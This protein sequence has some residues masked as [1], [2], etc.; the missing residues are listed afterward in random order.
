MCQRDI[1]ASCFDR[2]GRPENQ[3]TS[4]PLG[5]HISDAG[6]CARNVC[7]CE[8]GYVNRDICLQDQSDDCWACLAGYQKI[9]NHCLKKSKRK[10]LCNQKGFYAVYYSVLNRFTCRQF[11]ASDNTHDVCVDYSRKYNKD[12]TMQCA[13]FFAEVK[14]E[15]KGSCRKIF[16][17]LTQNVKPSKSSNK[18]DVRP[19]RNTCYLIRRDYYLD[20]VT[21]PVQRCEKM[22][23]F[24]VNF[25]TGTYCLFGKDYLNPNCEL[26][27][28]IGWIPGY[29][30]SKTAI[31]S[32]QSKHSVK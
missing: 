20:S 19:C 22:K 10:A 29:K 28:P 15:K 13:R 11:N 30:L 8:N 5:Q 1:D 4:C 32:D 7:H 24:R 6:Y 14:V 12:K 21:K 26:T 23:N 27:T 17:C 3:P 18:F 16:R 31:L 25:E 2:A 9:G